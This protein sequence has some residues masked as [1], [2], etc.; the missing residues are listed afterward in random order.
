MYSILKGEKEFDET[1]DEFS[2]FEQ[3]IDETP[4]E[5]EYNPDIPNWGI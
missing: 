4:V 3:K 2:T 5:V 1:A